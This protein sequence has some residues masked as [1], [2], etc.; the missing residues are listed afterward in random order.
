MSGV[1]PWIA[2]AACLLACSAAPEGREEASPPVIEPELPAPCEE[3]T[4]RTLAG[5]CESFPSLAVARSPQAI[6]PVR[7]HH[8]TMVIET[9]FGPYLYVFGGTDAWDAIHDDVQRAPI[10]EDGALGAFEA[11]GKLPS[12]RAGH[13]TVRVGDH[14]L[15]AGG[16]LPPGG[17]TSTT[18][19]AR[20]TPDG[21]LTDFAPGPELPQAVMHLS[22]EVHGDAVFALGGRGRTSRSTTL[23]ARATFSADGTLSPFSLDTP[24]S[25]DRSHHAS[26]I[27]GDRV[28]LLGGITGDP[29]RQPEERTDVVSAELRDDGRLGPWEPAG[30]LPEAISVSSALLYKDAVYVFGGLEGSSGFSDAVRRATFEDDGAL[31][32]FVTLDARLPDPRGHVH[33]TPTWG[34]FVYSVGGK[35]DSGASIGEVDV[36]R[37]E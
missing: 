36:G 3:G 19:L 10:G 32:P 29:I 27:R 30:T 6:D 1:R 9:T 14:L 2:F 37:F 24:L 12:P 5:A 21:A 18:L 26:F 25:P 15:F 23:S 20:L 16:V 13:C 8:T 31:T 17:P 4:Y 33:Q 28:Y 11:V 34:P 7:D 35:S 22:C